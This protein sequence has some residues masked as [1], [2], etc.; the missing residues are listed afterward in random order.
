MGT[1]IS[2]QKSLEIATAMA[3]QSIGKRIAEVR[4]DMREKITTAVLA[5]IPAELI[6][7]SSGT[8]SGYFNFACN[9]AVCHDGVDQID[10]DLKKPI[11]SKGSWRIVAEVSKKEHSAIASLSRQLQD[12]KKEQ[13]ELIAS[14][15]GTLNSLST[16]KKIAHSFPEAFEIIPK[17]WMDNSVV[18]LAIPIE[19]IR[20]NLLKY[21]K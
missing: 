4:T 6:E 3:E 13:R 15:E 8:Y 9:A 21:S 12:L 18:A 17:E 2:K 16:Y 10:C 19:S 20:E 7:L 14:I 5:K 11:P 1:K